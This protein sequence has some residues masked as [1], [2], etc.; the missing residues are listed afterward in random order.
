M[1]N[2]RDFLEETIGEQLIQAV[3]SGS[4]D[5]SGPSKVKIRPVEL[6][7]EILYQASETVGPKV[8]H[9][10]YKKEEI[11]AFLLQQLN[12]SFSQLLVQGRVLD[13]TVLVSK[14]GKVTIKKK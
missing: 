9:K 7:G 14:K 1:E 6:K 5:S 12:G 13:G 10:N 11:C 2:L 4:K 3:L 8:L